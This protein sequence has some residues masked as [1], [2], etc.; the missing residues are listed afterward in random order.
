MEER[1][2]LELADR[3][4]HV[5]VRWGMPSGVRQQV[6]DDPLDLRGLRLDRHRMSVDG[7]ARGLDHV[8]LGHHPLHQ[9]SDV[10]GR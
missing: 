8:G 5:G 9:L 1:A 2:A 7:Q 10:G 6:L 4:P 3:H